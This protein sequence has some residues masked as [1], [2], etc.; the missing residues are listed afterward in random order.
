MPEKIGAINGERNM[1]ITYVVF[2][3]WLFDPFFWKQDGNFDLCYIF[4]SRI[5]WSSK[6]NQKLHRSQPII[7][8][9]HVRRVN[10]K[11]WQ[12]PYVKLHPCVNPK[13]NWHTKSK[14]NCTHCFQSCL[15]AVVGTPQGCLSLLHQWVRY[16]LVGDPAPSAG[17]DKVERNTSR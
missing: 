15:Y 12:N 7:D 3:D 17:T 10:K 6:R 5:H 4:N 11:M 1:F 16:N 13:H 14:R 8:S 2:Y 9:V